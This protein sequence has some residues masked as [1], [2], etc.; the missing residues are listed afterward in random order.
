MEGMQICAAENDLLADGKAKEENGY[1]H[2][3]EKDTLLLICFCNQ[4]V[5]NAFSAVYF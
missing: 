5:K 4:M 1:P 2:S 3:Y